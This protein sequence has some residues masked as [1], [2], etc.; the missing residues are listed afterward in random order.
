MSSN[1]PA[2]VF[3]PPAPATPSVSSRRR[4]AFFPRSGAV[5]EHGKIA[6]PSRLLQIR[7]HPGPTPSRAG[8]TTCRCPN[9]L[10]PLRSRGRGGAPSVA[11]ASAHHLHLRG[12]SSC[13][14]RR[15]RGGWRRR[16]KGWPPEKRRGRGMAAGEGA[17][18]EWTRPR[19]SAGGATPSATVSCRRSSARGPA[20]L[21]LALTPPRRP[22]EL[23]RIRRG[24]GLPTPHPDPSGAAPP[25]RHRRSS[26]RRE[27]TRSAPPKGI[28][29]PP[30][31]LGPL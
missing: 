16:R 26:D 7:R 22:M 10:A 20:R 23:R 17:G 14:P 27:R 1:C 28:A 25:R 2:L 19:T 3:R 18:E 11:A 31:S 8:P 15:C 12:R 6:V 29:G 13:S 24:G 5:Q 4:M 30:P 21:A 9:D